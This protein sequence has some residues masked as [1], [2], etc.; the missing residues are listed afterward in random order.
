M[1]VSDSSPLI[2]LG[3][4]GQLDILKKCFK[5]VLI[6]KSVYEEIACKKESYEAIALNNAIKEKWISVQKTETLSKLETEKLGK[7]EKES[8]SLAIKHKCLLIMDDGTA[9]KYASIFKVDAHGTFY[10]ILLACKKNF[11]DKSSAKGLLESMMAEGFYI[12][13]EVH[14]RFLKMI[15][16][17]K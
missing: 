15:A 17:L 11:L 13:S 16:A 2:M 6:S 1:I 12:S 3:K 7:G 8:I 14:S 10:V 5:K 4:Q 9:K